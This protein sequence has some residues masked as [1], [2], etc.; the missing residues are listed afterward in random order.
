M[1]QDF[2]QLAERPFTAAPYAPHYCSTRY[3]DK[4]LQLAQQVIDES[5]GTVLVFGEHGVGKSMFLEV[6]QERYRNFYRVVNLACSTTATRADMLQNILF[7]LDRPYQGMNE[8]ELRLALMDFLKPS[9]KCKNGL[10]LLVDDAQNLSVELL[11]ELNTL[12]GMV[13]EGRLRTRIVMAG[14]QKLEETLTLPALNSFSQRVAAR[15]YLQTMSREESGRYVEQHMLRTG[16]RMGELFEPEAIELAIQVAGGVPRV[17][18]QVLSQSMILAAVQ[19]ESRIHAGLVDQAWQDIQSLPAH[20]GDAPGAEKA[21]NDDWSVVEFGTMEAAS[22]GEVFDDESLLPV[23][24]S[25]EA[26]IDDPSD[27][28]PRTIAEQSFEPKLFRGDRD[29]IDPAG[30]GVLRPTPQAES[31]ANAPWNLLQDAPEQPIAGNRDAALTAEHPANRQV[32]QVAADVF[33]DD[34]QQVEIVED[35]FAQWA[36][37]QNR[38]S[39][40]VT[41]EQLEQLMAQAEQVKRKLA[42][43]EL[44]TS[45]QEVLLPGADQAIDTALEPVFEEEAAA[46]LADEDLGGN[47]EPEAVANVRPV[48]AVEDFGGTPEPNPAKAPS[49]EYP[50]AEHSA[51]AVADHGENAPNDDDRGMLLVSYENQESV[52]KR[53]DEPLAAG[54]AASQGTAVRMDYRRLFDQLRQSS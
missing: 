3:S 27:A 36:A 13:R 45:E 50:L 19:S 31:I 37:Q 49:H 10:L 16:R 14:T 15:C 44:C 41:D 46:V 40:E 51:Y 42:E 23:D 20:Y 48:R 5:L 26:T 28:D 7:E 2:F 53:V 9:E 8:G 21:T 33:G 54:D 30:E 47:P 17:L 4:A 24:L 32:P 39:L 18:N 34:F 38:C 22:T 1:Y 6:L 35:R 52:K 11:L 12:S 43:H 29:S 25:S